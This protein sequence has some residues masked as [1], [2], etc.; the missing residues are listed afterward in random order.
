MRAPTE[1]MAQTWSA[2]ATEL[3]A[4]EQRTTAR[5]DPD[6]DVILGR[7]LLERA[8]STARWHVGQPVSGW[9]S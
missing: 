8:V 1:E 2:T 3:H 4:T 7:T 9:P 6:A 5:Q